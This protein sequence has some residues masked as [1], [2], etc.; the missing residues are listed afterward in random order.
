M[1]GSSIRRGARKRRGDGRQTWLRNYED[2]SLSRLHVK[3]PIDIG[4]NRW[5]NTRS[6]FHKL[7]GFP[8]AR[9]SISSTARRII[10][11]LGPNSD[12]HLVTLD[13]GIGWIFYTFAYIH[14]NRKLEQASFWDFFYVMRKMWLQK[15]SMS[16]CTNQYMLIPQHRYF[17]RNN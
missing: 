5:G 6:R 4:A 3:Q 1:D 15:L 8:F 16:R 11:I 10:N 12:I 17:N 13:N 14:L 7:W 9:P 2:S